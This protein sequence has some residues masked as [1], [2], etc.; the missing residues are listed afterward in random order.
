M[1]EWRAVPGYEGKYEVSDDGQV[2]SLRR[3]ITLRAATT[4]LGYK[5][6]ALCGK[7][8]RVHQL[9]LEGFVGPRPDGLITRHLN[10]KPGDNRLENLAYG[11]MKENAAD[12]LAHGVLPVA[13]RDHCHNGHKYT[14]E[15][16]SWD[17]RPNGRYIRRCRICRREYQNEKNRLARLAKQAVSA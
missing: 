15:N 10:G 13:A 14:P 11:T 6:V 5:Y 17:L 1:A 3:N 16:T 9:V 8:R 7:T 12:A 4:P 2:R